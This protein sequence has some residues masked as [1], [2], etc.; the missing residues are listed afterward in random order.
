M[1]LNSLS[2]SA[3]CPLTNPALK[4]S[5]RLLTYGGRGKYLGRLLCLQSNR[6]AQC[7]RASE[8]RS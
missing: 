2:V 6:E 1:T 8:G 7:L 4:A 5:C 3:Q